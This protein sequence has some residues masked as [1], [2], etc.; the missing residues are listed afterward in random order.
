[1]RKSDDNTCHSGVPN[2]MSDGAGIHIRTAE[3]QSAGAQKHAIRFQAE[4]LDREQ[5][6]VFQ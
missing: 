6:I 4:T 2:D 5:I 1:M 3:N